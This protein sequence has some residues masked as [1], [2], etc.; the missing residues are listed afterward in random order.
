MRKRLHPAWIGAFLVA[1]LA[2]S[3]LSIWIL[4]AGRLFSQPIRFV[5]V[6]PDS[7]NGLREG[8]LVKF[9]GVPIG[10]VR[11]LVIGMNTNGHPANIQVYAEIDP[12]R[13][14]DRT[15]AT[16]TSDQQFLIPELVLK[17]LRA[18]L[19]LESF[20]TG[21]LYVS[22]DMVPDAPPA[23]GV[24]INASCPEVP[25]ETAGL[26][27]FLH[28]LEELN[29]GALTTKADH[30]LDRLNTLL[31]ALDMERWNHE[32]LETLEAAQRLLQ[33]PQATNVLASLTQA[34]RDIS[35]LASDMREDLGPL[36]AG[37]SR[38]TA[39]AQ[40][41]LK[42]LHRLAD[43]LNR[44]TAPDSPT[45]LELQAALR[46]LS[47]TAKALSRL[48]DNLAENPQSILTGPPRSEP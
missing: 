37:L 31:A 15:G 47:H 1:G 16:R 2:L 23:Q 19:A 33:S 44:L 18:R 34:A 38:T 3:L 30:L 43:Q 26:Q 28:S 45:L 48:A 29:I 11:R 7:V 10:E 8:S 20:V 39:Q 21:Q 22:L 40:L 41:I 25:V 46:N 12:A 5:M 17:G 27:E 9:K 35:V 4:S 24:L 14:I 42:D 6:F 36:N 32:V 13:L